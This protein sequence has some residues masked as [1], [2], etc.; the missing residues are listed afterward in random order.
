MPRG[1]RGRTWHI[2][3]VPPVFENESEWNSSWMIP[4]AACDNTN[5]FG[6]SSTY[7]AM[8]DKYSS[9]AVPFCIQSGH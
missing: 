5:G 4:R 6:Y 8:G 1:P 2:S 7:L 9:T 3:I